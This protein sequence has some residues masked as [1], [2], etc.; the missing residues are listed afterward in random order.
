MSANLVH[1]VTI[2]D[3]RT[4]LFMRKPAQDF[5]GFD[6]DNLPVFSLDMTLED[7]VIGDRVGALL[8][9]ECGFFF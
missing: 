9:A 6:L 3:P 1:R 5:G 8:A 2:S 7:N 4:S